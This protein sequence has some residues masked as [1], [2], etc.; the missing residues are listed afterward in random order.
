M[1]LHE[2]IRAAV[3]DGR[4]KDPWTT[5]DLLANAGL[6]E[7]FTESSLRTQP[8]NR[9]VSLS[10]L[11]LGT[12]ANAGNGSEAPFLRVGMRGK[13]ILYSVRERADEWALTYQAAVSAE[14][15]GAVSDS[16]TVELI[17]ESDVT[18]GEAPTAPCLPDG[19]SREALVLLVERMQQEE[20]WDARLRNYV[21]KGRTFEET[22]HDLADIILQGSVL[23]RFI[24]QG[25]EW[26][27]QDE[28]RAVTWATGI[29]DWGGTRQKS[30]VTW[31][32]VRHTL[33]NAVFNRV[34]YRDAPMN[35][36]YTKVA[37]FGT[38]YLDD[39]SSGTPQVINDSRVATSLTCRLDAILREH[40]WLPTDLFPGLGRVEAA[41]G[42][43]RPRPLSRGWPDAYQRWS[44]QFAATS[45]VLAIRDILNGDDRFPKMPFGERDVPWTVRGIEAVLFM[46]GY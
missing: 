4:M 17:V 9:S 37:S 22:Q 11:D 3:L 12:G 8:P 2:R 32:K 5:G 10:G 25:V 44:G 35:S 23:S 18:I 42:G 33:A 28:A 27:R 7:G 20:P 1:S 21:W 24:R 36:G 30:P 31:Q 38:A 6:F 34:E 46:D 39:G 40:G 14:Q 45:V 41:R 13:A 26:S 15:P 19:Q 16:T 29:F 43:T